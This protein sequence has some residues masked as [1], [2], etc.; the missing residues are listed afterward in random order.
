MSA[1]RRRLEAFADDFEAVVAPPEPVAARMDRS[2]PRPRAAAPA[3]RGPAQPPG[4]RVNLYGVPAEL[5]EDLAI[6]ARRLRRHAHDRRTINASS[7]MVA[8]I[9]AAV[10]RLEEQGGLAEELG[11]PRTRDELMQAARRALGVGEGQPAG[12]D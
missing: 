4:E 5:L 1:A 9:A 3:A 12:A 7:V 6:A 2:T 8:L 10:E 11:Q